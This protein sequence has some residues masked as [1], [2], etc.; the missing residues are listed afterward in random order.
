MFENTVY[1]NSNAAGRD[2]NDNGKEDAWETKI[3]NSLIKS[4]DKKFQQGILDFRFLADANGDEIVTKEEAED[5]L[6]IL[7]NNQD[8]KVSSEE[9]AFGNVFSMKNGGAGLNKDVVAQMNAYKENN[10]ITKDTVINANVT[11]KAAT[12]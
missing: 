10:G 11:N 2:L 12:S 1:T 5:A 4:D 6:K 7:D 8:G 3:T 9:I